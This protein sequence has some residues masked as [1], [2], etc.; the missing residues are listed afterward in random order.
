MQTYY[1]ENP[2]TN[3]IL[4]TKN[5]LKEIQHFWNH[6]PRCKQSELI[7]IDGLTGEI[8]KI[9]PVKSK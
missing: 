8:L 3:N 5:T 1:I 4:V 7:L 2:K 6:I 9:K